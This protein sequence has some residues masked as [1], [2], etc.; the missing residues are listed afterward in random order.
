MNFS[1]RSEL[2]GSGIERSVTFEGLQLS[3]PDT[4]ARVLF[5]DP[6]FFSA[7]HESEV[8]SDGRQQQH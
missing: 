7:Q 6:S 1:S 5:Q 3:M 4:V 2:G 8:V